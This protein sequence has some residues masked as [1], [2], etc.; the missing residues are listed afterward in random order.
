MLIA[1]SP[2]VPASATAAWRLVA[3]GAT[4]AVAAVVARTADEARRRWRRAAYRVAL[5]AT[6]VGS[7]LMLRDLLPVVQ[8]PAL[9]GLLQRI[10]VALFGVEP[11]V[12]AARFAT[13]PV[14]EYFAFFYF[15]Y[16]A[17][18]GLYALAVMGLGAAGQ[19]TAEFTIGAALV[20][21]I[22]Q[23]GYAVVPGVGPA[24]HLAGAFD[25]PLEGGLFWR[26]VQATVGAAGAI[27]DIFPSL[28]TAAPVWFTIF[29]ARRARAT[30]S[31]AWTAFAVVTG[32][33]ALNIVLST[34]VL[35]WH[36]VADVFAGLV[37]A[38]G[39]GWAAPRLA[40]REA[41]ARARAGLEPVWP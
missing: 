35:R 30:A 6:I 20:Y 37:L 38:A 31:R 19:G 26:W 27:R 18:L 23:L 14:V 29:A 1:V 17:I 4:L 28:H 8:G 3:S 40:A 5:T 41:S 16:F 36:Y 34:I 32:W 25:A 10:D 24:V 33:F 21:C 7:Y 39:V 2:A 15:S 22:G 11:A 12:W 9:D 13:P